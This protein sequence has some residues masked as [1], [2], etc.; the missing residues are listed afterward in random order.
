MMSRRAS[1]P[2]PSLLVLAP[3]RTVP[4]LAR[5]RS[6]C[7]QPRARRRGV[8]LRTMLVSLMGLLLRRRVELV[9]AHRGRPDGA[10]L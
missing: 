3:R 1:A 10:A 4:A 5:P 7:W 2:P 8:A 6:R 9:V